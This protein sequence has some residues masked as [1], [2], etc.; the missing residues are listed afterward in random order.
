MKQ[1]RTE[2]NRQSRERSLSYAILSVALPLFALLISACLIV[3]CAQSITVRPVLT[4]ELGEESPDASAFLN[5]AGTASYLTGPETR[6][7]TAGNRLLRIEVGGRVRPVVLRVRDTVAPT[8]QGTETTVSVH[9][10]PGPDKLV[11][12]LKDKSVVRLTFLSAPNYGTVGDWN[13]VIGLEDA[14]GNKSQV[15]VTVHVRLVRESVTIEAGDPAP[16][17]DDFL[18]SGVSGTLETEITKQTTTVP[19]TYPIRLTADGAAVESLLIVE[20]TVSPEATGKT[21]IIKPGEPV[22]PQDLLE[23]VTDQ[24]AVACTFVNAPDPDSR[25]MQQIDVRIRDLGGNETVVPAALLFTDVA[26][27]T[28]E[29]DTAPLSPEAILTEGTYETA[30]F[31]EPFV[32]DTVGTHAAAMQID[33]TE[34]VALIEVRDTRAPV[35]TVSTG[36]W[37]LN[38]P[39]GPEQFVTVSD[40]TETA[41]SF[42]Q[43]PDWT[44]T[45]QKVTVLAVDGGGNRASIRFDLKLLPDTEPPVLYGVRNR[46]CYVGEPVAYLSEVSA[47]DACDGEVEVTVDSSTVNASKKGSYYVTYTATDR[48]GNT[49]SKRVTFF[50]FKP[51]VTEERAKEVADRIIERIFTD[52]MTLKEQIRAIH[53]YVFTHVHYVSRSDKRD[54][55]S[56]AVRGLTTR[57]RGFC[58]NGPTPKS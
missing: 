25:A 3:F 8:A 34:N 51:K 57:R 52:G 37:Y 30:D 24:T 4:I 46:N 13:A 47:V 49:V 48:A 15:P 41:L 28:V 21:L 10:S 38:A 50:F 26:P 32:P 18:L 16:G 45:E 40:A 58:S 55:R 23:T 35:L 39:R 9:E 27:V 12:N 56:E 6:Y 5:R 2:G 7:R 31:S 14:S 17:A 22:R 53:D 42:E 19:G 43:E 11:K 36:Q 44:K 20:D 54:W 29:A 33:G 1:R